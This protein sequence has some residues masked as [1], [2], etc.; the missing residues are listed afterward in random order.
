MLG[1]TSMQYA[2]IDNDEIA[3]SGH[4]G[5][6]GKFEDKGLT[7]DTMYGIVDLLVRCM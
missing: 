3:L 1:S 4:T 5:V 2:M 7:D 6:Y